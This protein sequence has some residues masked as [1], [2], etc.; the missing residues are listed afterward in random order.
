MKLDLIIKLKKKIG[1]SC[2]KNNKENYALIVGRYRVFHSIYL[3]FCSLAL[4]KEKKI[5]QYYLNEKQLTK[6]EKNLFLNFGIGPKNYSQRLNIIQY[7]VIFIKLVPLFMKGACIIIFSNFEKFVKDFKV[8]D[9]NIGDLIFDSYLRYG[10]RFKNPKFDIYLI[11]YLFLGTYKTLLL[12]KFFDEKKLKYL[13][14][15][16]HTYA[17][18]NGISTRVA[19]KKGI[20]VIMSSFKELNFYSKEKIDKGRYYLN[21]NHGLSKLKKIPYS[22]KIF[23]KYYISRKKLDS[24]YSFTRERTLNLLMEVKTFFQ[25]LNF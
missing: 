15:S 17:N 3:L 14:L 20:K 10:H 7:S 1:I 23:L 24:D 25:E 12:D 22:K 13:V 5:N 11:Y 2:K 16:G 8:A 18:T 9:I 21:N 4:N 19:I 6:S